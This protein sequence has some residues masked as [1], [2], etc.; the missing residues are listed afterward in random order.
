MWCALKGAIFRKD[1]MLNFTE[2]DKDRFWAKVDISAGADACWPWLACTFQGYGRFQHAHR[3]HA[4][5]R[6]AYG[7]T[8]EPISKGLN[9]CHK[10]DNPIC[11]NPSHIFIGTQAD[12]IAD[13]H[14]KGRDAKG[15]RNGSRTRPDR[16]PRG[17]NHPR[18][19]NPEL[20]NPPP[21]PNW[22]GEEVGTS[23]LTNDQ[24]IEI[25]RLRSSGYRHKEIAA[26]F[27]VSWHTVKSVANRNS[28]KHLP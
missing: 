21:P 16:V 1:M 4:A 10:C 3:A 23:I 25:R 5:H 22:H 28:W 17:E 27:G 7:L 9:G 11:C 12:N 2:K 13:R 8:Y 6:I 20:F 26:M 24:V 15:D 14:S 18:R 19:K